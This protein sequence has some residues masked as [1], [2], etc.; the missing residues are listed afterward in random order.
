M[1]SERKGSKRV[2]S[3]ARAAGQSLKRAG[4]SRGGERRL[5][6][7]GRRLVALLAGRLERGRDGADRHSD[8]AGRRLGRRTGGGR[9]ARTGVVGRADGGRAGRAAGCLNRVAAGGRGRVAVAGRLLPED[10]LVPIPPLCKGESESNERARRQSRR[11]HDTALRGGNA[12]DAHR[13]SNG[14][15]C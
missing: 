12:R 4:R 7:H 14:R 13:T 1:K 6:V 3:R 15:P 11:L 9:L 2:A 8:R 10:V 5:V